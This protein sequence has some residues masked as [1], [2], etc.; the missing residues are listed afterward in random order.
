MHWAKCLCAMA[1]KSLRT[2]GQSVGGHCVGGTWV[3]HGW[4]MG[5]WVTGGECLVDE[6]AGSWRMVKT[7]GARFAHGCWV[8]AE[9]VLDC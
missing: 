3:V 1:T 4:W 6:V 9:Q 5:W 8:G 2:V 7:G